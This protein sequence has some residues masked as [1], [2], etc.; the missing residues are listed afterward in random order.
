[1]DRNDWELTWH[2]LGKLLGSKWSCHVLRLLST[3]SYRFNE[4]TRELDGMTA[5]VLSRRLKELR[6]HGL[7]RREVGNQSPPE[8]R[9]DLTET[10]R[11]IAELLGQMEAFVDV[12]R[13]AAETDCSEGCEPDSLCVTSEREKACITLS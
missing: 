5:T 7:V 12:D 3:G 1:M 4:L 8:T 11:A 13:P 6:C 10:G 9:Y 2:T